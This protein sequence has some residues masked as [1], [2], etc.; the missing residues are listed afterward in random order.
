MSKTDGF[1]PILTCQMSF[2]WQIDRYRNRKLD[3]WIDVK[4]VQFVNSVELV[5]LVS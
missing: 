3:G 4:L 1:K 2:S 5:Q